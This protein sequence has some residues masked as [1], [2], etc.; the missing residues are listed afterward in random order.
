M[1]TQGK[2]ILVFT[3]H[4]VIIGHLLSS[5]SHTQVI[6]AIFFRQFVI[7][8]CPPASSRHKCHALRAASHY[9]FSHAGLYFG[10]GHGNRFQSGTAVTVNSYSC[11][12]FSDCFVGYDTTH[13]EALFR[14]RNSIAHYHVIDQSGV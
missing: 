5:K 11:S 4:V 3:G 9:A 2:G 12:P 8:H 13:L 7:R 10:S 1:G 6:V 14:F